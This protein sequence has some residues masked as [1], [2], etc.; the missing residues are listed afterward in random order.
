M[1]KMNVLGLALIALVSCSW[2]A[3][4]QQLSVANLTLCGVRLGLHLQTR[5]GGVAHVSQLE[6]LSQTIP[7]ANCSLADARC[8]CSSPSLPQL[9]AACLLANCS[10]HDSLGSCPALRLSVSRLC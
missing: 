6:C 1:I 9:T 7:Q 5:V 8:Q 2:F 3:G 4:A 10:M